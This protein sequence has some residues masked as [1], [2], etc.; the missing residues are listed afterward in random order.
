M[1]KRSNRSG[2]KSKAIFIGWQ[3]GL[4]DTPLALFNITAD[5]HP[6]NGSTVCET[7]LREFDIQVPVVPFY[8]SKANELRSSNNEREMREE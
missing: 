5:G 7:T 6:S 2:K 3:K 1:A 4:V 8:K